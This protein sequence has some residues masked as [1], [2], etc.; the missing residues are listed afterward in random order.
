MRAPFRSILF[1]G[2]KSLTHK[3]KKNDEY[4]WTGGRRNFG[5]LHS[6]FLLFCLKK[7][8]REKIS[9]SENQN[10]F[11]PFHVRREDDKVGKTEIEDRHKKRKKKAALQ[12]LRRRNNKNNRVCVCVCVCVFIS[13]DTNKRETTTRKLS[14]I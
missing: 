11:F 5:F 3:K 13:S 7:C 4:T 1:F 2:L 6:T 9:F 10:I 8:K 14:Y 12:R